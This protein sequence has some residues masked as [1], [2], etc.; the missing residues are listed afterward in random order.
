MKI[1]SSRELALSDGK[2]G[3]KALVAVDG[4]VYDL[5]ASK[6]WISGTHMNRHHA[7]MDL[8][9]DIRS[10][11]HGAEIVT[12]FE[13]VGLLEEVS[14]PVHGGLRGTVDAWLERH[15][16]F[17]RHPH[18]A[19]VHFPVGLLL[20]VPIFLAASVIADSRSTEWAAYCCLILGVITVPAAMLSGYFTWWINYGAADSRI[21]TTKKH[22]AWVVLVVGI[23]AV[24]LRSFTVSDP[25]N[26]SDFFVIAYFFFVPVLSAIVGYVGFLGGK[27][28]IP[29][30]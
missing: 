19:I 23:L 3:R 17:R 6:R 18:P 22:L 28:T 26:T 15:P 14:E 30:E 13:V 16:F 20:A 7:G 4:K 27:L 5:S 25:I 21:I 9:K 29:Y 24:L 8:N 12:R 10:A 2:E 1:Y 11:P